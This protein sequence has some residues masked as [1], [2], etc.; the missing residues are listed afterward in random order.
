FVLQSNEVV[1]LHVHSWDAGNH[2]FH[3]HG[4][5][6]QVVYKSTDVTSDDPSLNPPVGPEGQ[7]NPMCRDMIKVPSL[8]TA[9]LRIRA[10]NPGAWLFHCK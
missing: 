6:F 5:K 2:P 1:E 9:F 10:D 8:G 3:L 7:A 4:H